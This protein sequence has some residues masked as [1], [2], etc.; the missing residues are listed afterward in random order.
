MPE[1]SS[2]CFN[3]CQN[4]FGM[5]QLDECSGK[6]D[7]PKMNGRIWRTALQNVQVSDTTGAEGDYCSPLQNIGMNPN[8]D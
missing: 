7:T 8:T 1:G 5:M 4:K 3:S 6:H 2:L